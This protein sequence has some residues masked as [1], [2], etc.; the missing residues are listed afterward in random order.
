MYVIPLLYRVSSINDLLSITRL[1][2]AF[3][4]LIM[5]HSTLRTALYLDTNGT[6]IQHCLDTNDIQSFGFSFTNLHNDDRHIN[7]IIEEILN[8]SDLFD[9]SKGRVIRCHILHQSNSKGDDNTLSLQNGDFILISI[10][11]GVFDGASTS[12]FIRDLS[13]AYQTNHSLHVDDNTLQYID[14]SVHERLIDMTLSREFWHSELERY[15]LEHRLSLPVDRSRSLTDQRSGLASSAYITFDNTICTSFLDYASSHHL[16]LFQLGLATF[17]VFLFKLTHGESDLCIAS[18]NANRY[19][20]ELVNMIGM[21]VSTSPYR[22]EL[23][24]HWSF[25]ELVQCTREKCLSILEHSHYPLQSIL[26]DSHLNQSNVPFLDTV[27]DF[28]NISP[29]IQQI[30]FDGTSLEEVLFQQLY[31]TAKF[32]FMLRFIHNPISENDKLSCQLVCSRDLFDEMTVAKIAQRFEHLILQLFSPNASFLQTDRSAAAIEK[33]SL[34]LPEEV[35]EIEDTVF[36]RQSNI[37][38]EGMFIY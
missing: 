19:R 17:Y 30:S 26:A 24:S 29:D 1:Y 12:I 2:R 6:I 18:I 7:E 35:R 16:T 25:D 10:Y 3:Q 13:F 5:K 20:N 36:C 21:F 32:D 38:N 4:S 31:E 37:V 9:F 8:Q 22:I 15:N 14:Y 34:I 28:V 33:I 11:H 23:D 27:L